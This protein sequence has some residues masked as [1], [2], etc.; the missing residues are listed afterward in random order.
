MTAGELLLQVEERLRG[1][2]LQRSQSSQLD[3]GGLEALLEV[4]VERRIIVWLDGGLLLGATPKFG[5][6]DDDFLLAT[7]RELLSGG[8]ESDRR[9]LAR[10][11]AAHLGYSQVTAAMRDRLEEVVEEGVRRGVLARTGAGRLFRPDS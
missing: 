6:Y 5:R 9:V 8:L 10:A 1:V 4:A 2:R 7:I 3:R 11:V